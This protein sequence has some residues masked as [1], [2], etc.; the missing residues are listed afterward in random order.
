MEVDTTVLGLSKEEAVKKSYIASM[1]VYVFKKEILLNLLR[2]HCN[3]YGTKRQFK[4]KTVARIVKSDAGKV[5]CREAERIK[6]AAV[7]LGSRGR[8]L[9]QRFASPFPLQL[10]NTVLNF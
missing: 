7:V 1:G 5:I 2:S 8:S 6:P 4:V 10:S 3:S 9:I